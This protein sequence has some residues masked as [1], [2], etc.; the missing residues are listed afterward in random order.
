MIVAVVIYTGILVGFSVCCVWGK[1]KVG[2]GLSLV[3]VRCLMLRSSFSIIVAFL[4]SSF[5]RRRKMKSNTIEIRDSK[6]VISVRLFL[7]A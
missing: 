3:D 6:L 5:V 1:M 2:G 4:A 7:V